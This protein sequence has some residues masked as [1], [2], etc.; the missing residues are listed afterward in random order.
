[1]EIIICIIWMVCVLVATMIGSKKG[2]GVF[3][4]IAGFL[5]GPIGV[6]MAIFSKGDRKSCSFCKESIHKDA[7]VC[8]HCQK[9]IEQLLII[10]CPSCR[11]QAQMRES[12]LNERIECPKC[13]K[14]F[15]ASSARN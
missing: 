14:A 4:F 7:T 9:A 8:P 2:E 5:L 6:L 15:L 11:K 3:G 1:M 13:K 12:L 10:R